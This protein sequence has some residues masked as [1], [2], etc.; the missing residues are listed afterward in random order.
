MK[1]ITRAA[2]SF[3]PPF[4]VAGLSYV[5]TAN[6][7]QVYESL[8]QPPLSPPSAVFPWVWSILFLL[9]GVSF[10]MVLKAS[11]TFPKPTALIYFSQLAV[12]FLWSVFFFRAQWFWFSFFWLLFLLVM[13]V[14][15]IR[16]F[17]KIRP[18]AALLQ[19]PYLAWVSFA[20]Y[21]NLMIA[22]L[23]EGPLL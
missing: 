19:I 23:N 6:A 11:P 1:K 22:L 7:S 20:G 8:K 15:M 4:A 9:M 2:L 18:A 5:F 21:L 13:I 17:Y 12:N 10:F 14:A 16:S 3:L